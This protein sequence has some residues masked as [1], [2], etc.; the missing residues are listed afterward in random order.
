MTA[1]MSHAV[2]CSSSRFAT[3]ST[4]AAT[5]ATEANTQPA[6][7]SMYRLVPLSGAFES[8]G[9]DRR[10]LLQPELLDRQLAQLVLLDLAGDGDG[11]LVDGRDVARDL[12]AGDPS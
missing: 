8:G 2:E 7:R 5:T 1:P 4:A 11:E 10:G 3:R 12:V 9:L 6:V